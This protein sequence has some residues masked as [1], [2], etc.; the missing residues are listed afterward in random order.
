M[1]QF[2]TTNAGKFAEVSEKLAEVH[3][4]VV[5][6]DRSYPEIQ[7][8]RLEKVVK[9]AATVLDDEVKADYLIDD[10]GLFI[11]TLGGFPGVYSAYVQKRLGNKGILKLMAG[12]T[13]R[14]AHFETV[15]LLKT[16][17]DHEVFHGECPGTIAEAERGK[18][19]FG[20]DPIFI[21]EG[22]TRTF[23]EMSLKEKNAVSHRAR[24][25]DA[26]TRYLGERKQA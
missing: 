2:I 1:I 6:L 10:S 14:A 5:Q 11:E 21:P 26:L 22:G 12:E 25:V 23:G 20:Y 24:A 4:K 15:F 18:G 3:V 7:T 19:G 9:Y 16:G 17:E 13:Y 8:E